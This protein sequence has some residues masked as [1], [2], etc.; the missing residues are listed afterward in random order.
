MIK[1]VNWLLLALGDIAQ[2]LWHDLLGRVGAALA[3]LSEL[4]NPVLVPV[5]AG[6]NAVVNRVAGLF[7]SPIG[8]L[9]GWLSNTIISAVA[10]VLMLLVFKY[11]SN[12]KAIG[13][14]KDDIKAD[15]LALKLFKDELSVTFRSQG[16]VFLGSLRLLRY[17][18]LPLLVMIVPVSLL[19]GQMGLWY[20]W[21]PLS[22]GEEALMTMKLTGDPTADMPDVQITSLP[23][24]E[25]VLG[26]VRVISKREVCWQIRAN[27]PGQHR[28]VF[29]VGAEQVD[30]QLVVGEGFQRTSPVRPGPQWT[31]LVL[32]PLEP[33]FA[34]GAAVHS[35]SIDYPERDSWTCGTDWWLL[36][37]FVVSLVFAL[38]AKPLLRVRI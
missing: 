13:R 2:W 35:I 20:Q 3:W 36:Y 31:S 8:L 33:H 14:V 23:G 9:P 38:I 1:A 27:D 28:I 19:L 22:P 11:T 34:Q 15:L 37:F 7:L 12:Q 29:R 6:V 24:A 18:L 16:R 32:H 30:K 5:F 25:V 17:A 10:G 26:P 21:R 4:A